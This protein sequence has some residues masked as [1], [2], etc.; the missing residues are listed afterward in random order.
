M[1]LASYKDGSR[2]GQLLVVSSDLSMAH[3]AT[4]IAT[5]L[6]QVLDDWNF[7]SPQLQELA[8]SLDHGKARHAFAFDP[9]RCMAPLPR[10][11]L[12]AQPVDGETTSGQAAPAAGNLPVLCRS[13]MLRGAGD[14]ID[15]PCAASGFTLQAGI[16]AL[17]GDIAAGSQAHEALE[18]LRLLVLAAGIDGSADA[19]TPL[20][21]LRWAFAPV[22]I[23][24]DELGASWRGDHAALSLR[25]QRH[26]A[27][28]IKLALGQPERTGLGALL[29]ALA[30]TQ[31]LR[32]GSIV[33]CG[34]M[35]LGADS[36][37]GAAG[38]GNI[39]ADADAGSRQAGGRAA[40]RVQWPARLEALDPAGNS[41]FGAIALEMIA[42]AGAIAALAAPAEPPPA[43]DDSATPAEPVAN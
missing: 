42:P 39:D 17:T 2:D 32:A 11:C 5:R 13:D 19:D 23:T 30:A 38:N 16:A 35:R 25:L 14:P 4:G 8:Q 21:A 41:P 29:A 36:G 9:R 6:Q 27:P 28:A 31:G 26:G 18:G 15:G 43:P 24:P 10:A 37:D 3:Y 40:G 7:L 12:H 20:G 22:A 1:K 34:L 33:G